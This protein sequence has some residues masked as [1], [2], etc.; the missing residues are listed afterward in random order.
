MG[1]PARISR[2]QILGEA[3]KMLANGGLEGLSIRQLAGVLDTV[4]TA[5]YNHFEN[6]EAIVNAVAESA[7]TEIAVTLDSKAG[8]D[9]NIRTW[10]HKTRNILVDAPELVFLIDY[11]AALPVILQT[12]LQLST[13]MQQGGIEKQE[14][15][16]QAQGLLWLVTSFA[17]NEIQTRHPKRG[18]RYQQTYIEKPYRELATAMAT[19]D[20]QLLWKS[21]VEREVCG[22]LGMAK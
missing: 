17:H 7:L 8:W 19:T 9:E 13:V 21:T 14:S 3:R 2:E 5:L 22:L 16:R 11:A 12:L 1:R 15:Y 6:K 20:C 4:P 10:L 18:K